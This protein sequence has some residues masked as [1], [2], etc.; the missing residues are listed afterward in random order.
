MGINKITVELSDRKIGLIDQVMSY[1]VCEEHAIG[2]LLEAG[3][4]FLEEHVSGTRDFSDYQDHYDADGVNVIEIEGSK[5]L[6]LGT[7]VGIEE[8]RVGLPLTGTVT[9]YI[10][11]DT[12]AR[13]KLTPASVQRLVD[14][15]RPAHEYIS[16]AVD[17]MIE[18]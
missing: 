14:H 17:E 9:E 13:V 8:Y 11:D 2:W 15:G 3:Q 4:A 1:G 6:P 5:T 10:A 18:L 7:V 12:V 16:C